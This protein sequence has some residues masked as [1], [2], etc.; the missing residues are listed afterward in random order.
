MEVQQFTFFRPST[1]LGS[2]NI[3]LRSLPLYG[4]SRILACMSS[5]SVKLK[6]LV[7]FIIC[8]DLL[9]SCSNKC[10]V[11]HKS[12]KDNTVETPNTSSFYEMILEVCELEEVF[13]Q[14]FLTKESPKMKQEDTAN[15][16]CFLAAAVHSIRYEFK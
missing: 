10:Q 7:C 16:L 14:V 9:V 11:R 3:M 5:R 13:L 8:T 12:K 15:K 6:D 1:S 2:S 4:I